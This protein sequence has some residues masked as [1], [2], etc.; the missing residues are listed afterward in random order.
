MCIQLVGVLEYREADEGNRERGRET[1]EKEKERVGKIV[2]G[3]HMGRGSGDGERERGREGCSSR[4]L[5][6]QYAS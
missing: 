6:S 5:L 4:R 1:C 2:R 3:I